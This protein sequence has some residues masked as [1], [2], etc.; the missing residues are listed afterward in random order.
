MGEALRTVAYILDHV[1][2]KYVPRTPYELMAEKRPTLKYFR[3]WA[4][5]AEVRLYNP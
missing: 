3:V 2:S 5:R 4:C 1:P